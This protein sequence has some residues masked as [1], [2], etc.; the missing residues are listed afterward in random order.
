MELAKRPMAPCELEVY[1]KG[2]IL[3]LVVGDHPPPPFP[4]PS[5]NK[6]SKNKSTIGR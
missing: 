6:S 4:H 3:F 1:P 5:K 2:L